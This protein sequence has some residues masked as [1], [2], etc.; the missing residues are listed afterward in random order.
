MRSYGVETYGVDI[1]SYAIK[2]ADQSLSKYL[3]QLDVETDDLPWPDG[4]FDV[5]TAFATLEHLF[6]PEFALKK[7]NKLL[8]KHGIIIVTLPNIEK[9]NFRKNN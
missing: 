8:K 2:C 1:S 7:L 5:I 3:Y 9:C 6:H 4:F